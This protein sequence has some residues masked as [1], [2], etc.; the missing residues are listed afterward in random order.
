[1]C[2]PLITERAHSWYDVYY[3]YNPSIYPNKQ[4]PVLVW[5]WA[6]FF[7]LQEVVGIALNPYNTEILLYNSREQSFC[8][9]EI[10]TNV[11]VC[12]FHFI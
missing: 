6:S 5:R 7:A 10:I 9:F 11:L 4:E 2:N 8:R 1:M 3:N 12:S